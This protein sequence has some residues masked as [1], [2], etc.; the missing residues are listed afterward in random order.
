LKAFPTL[1]SSELAARDFAAFEA[2]QRDLVVKLLRGRRFRLAA[3]FS[4]ALL[5]HAGVTTRE[6]EAVGARSLPARAIA[7]ALNAFLDGQLQRWTQGPFDLTPL[8]HHGDGSGEGGGM[9]YHRATRDSDDHGPRRRRF[10]VRELPR[11]LTQVIGH[12]RDKKS[13]E[14]LGLDPAGAKL[15]AVRRWPDPDDPATTLRYPDVEVSSD[16][17]KTWAPFDLAVRASLRTT[18]ADNRCHDDS[19]GNL[20][21]SVGSNADPS[22]PVFHRPATKEQLAQ[23]RRDLSGQ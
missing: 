9:L 5:T 6:L 20:Y 13:L 16:G 10:G 3:H 15:G 12:V 18:C 23:Y 7:G 14:L 11:G 4:G 2:R 21:R 17:G 19:H 22:T 1:P 8:H